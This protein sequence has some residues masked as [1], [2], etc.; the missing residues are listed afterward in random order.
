MNNSWN[1]TKTANVVPVTG[2]T[3]TGNVAFTGGL[4]VQST[5]S[6]NT[7]NQVA[8]FTDSERRSSRPYIT[9][10]YLGLFAAEHDLNRIRVGMHGNHHC[11]KFGLFG[12]QIDRLPGLRIVPY[13]TLSLKSSGADYNCLRVEGYSGQQSNLIEAF[14]SD[15]TLL[16]NLDP[17]GNC[18]GGTSSTQNLGST[19]LNW[20]NAF[21]QNA[22]II[23]SDQREKDYL[24]ALTVEEIKVADLVLGV[25]YQQQKSV[26]EKGPEKARLHFGISAQQLVESFQAAGL[27][28][29]R[30]SVNIENSW[31][32]YKKVTPAI[33][34]TEAITDL[35]TGLTMP[36]I[37]A[38][39]ETKRLVTANSLEEIPEEYQ[40]TA[41]LKNKLAVRYSELYALLFFAL[42]TRITDL[43]QKVEQLDK[44]H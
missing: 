36:A 35:E 3:F 44:K 43:E 20:K 8:R 4:S 32:E 17:L 33:E 40:S 10:G 16:F 11:I 6:G 25:V 34:K 38:Q 28:P 18:L 14:D 24:R 13:A 5:Y 41:V 26:K 39:P 21:L 31:Y 2:G 15:S 22:P 1:H 7:W 29:Y 27:D 42:K 30:Y 23:A 37:E 9:I 12:T 19:S